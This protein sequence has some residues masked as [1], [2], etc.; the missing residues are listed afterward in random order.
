MTLRA[1]REAESLGQVGKG[2]RS[3]KI[4]TNNYPQGRVSD[5]RI[6]TSSYNLPAVMDGAGC[7]HKSTGVERA[8]GTAGGG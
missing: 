7:L 6:N 4:R 5:H 3:E 8:G 1:E 2:D